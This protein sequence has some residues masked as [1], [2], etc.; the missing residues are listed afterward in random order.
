MSRSEHG[1]LRIIQLVISLGALITMSIHI[2]AVSLIQLETVGDG[3]QGI[4]IA[5]SNNLFYAILAAFTFAS[6]IAYILI[7][8][9]NINFG[10]TQGQKN[11]T[12]I[13]VTLASALSWLIIACIFIPTVRVFAEATAEIVRLSPI[14][15]RIRTLTEMAN[16]SIIAAVVIAFLLAIL[17]GISAN[18]LV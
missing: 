5:D 10:L 16:G 3:F 17:F 12:S 9:N 1:P 14:Q 8:R 13:I 7:R 2:A 15:N 6:S 4:Y 18:L 11:A